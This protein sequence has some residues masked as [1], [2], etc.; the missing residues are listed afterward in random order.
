MNIQMLE[1]AV[2]QANASMVL[3]HGLGADGGDLLPVARALGLPDVR[4]ILPDAPVQPVSLNNGYPMRSWFD[5]YGGEFPL[6]QD[7]AGLLSARATVQALVE[8]EISRGIPPHRILLGGFSQGGALALFSGLTLNYPFAGV[9]GLS[10]WLP[11]ME[12]V[13]EHPPAVWLAH[14]LYDSILP[15]ATSQASYAAWPELASSLHTWPMD[16]E[17]C[18]EEIEMLGKWIAARLAAQPAT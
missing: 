5:L 9:I 13:P 7:N 2:E 14:G 6:R 11:E 4:F 3:L 8:Q 17:I 12:H 15:L 16:H 1:P 18:A 10:T